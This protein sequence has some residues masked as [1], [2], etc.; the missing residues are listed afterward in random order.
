MRLHHGRI[1]LM[2]EATGAGVRREVYQV[3]VVLTWR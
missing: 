2:V 1:Y 3:T